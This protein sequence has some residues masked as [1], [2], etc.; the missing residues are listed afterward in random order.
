MKFK[1][2][3]GLRGLYTILM[4]QR[5]LEHQETIKQGGMKYAEE[6]MEDKG[7]FSSVFMKTHLGVDCLS[8]MVRIALLFPVVVV[9]PSQR[10]IYVLLFRQIRRGQRTL[11]AAA[12]SQLPSARNNP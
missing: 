8:L 4:K 12:D 5:R 3:I 6:L 2:A 11:P 1:E 10:E 9:A 7:Y